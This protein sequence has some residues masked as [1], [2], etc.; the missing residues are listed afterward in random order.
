MG[1]APALVPRC[2]HKWPRSEARFL[3]RPDPQLGGDSRDLS[4][5]CVPETL[6]L[7][8]GRVAGHEGRTLEQ[9]LQPQ[10]EPPSVS[11]DG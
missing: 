5:V 1:T 8:E 11:I 4:V 10:P 9:R 2:D 3:Q 7:L 6:P